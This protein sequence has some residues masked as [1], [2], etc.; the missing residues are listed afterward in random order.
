[1]DT[2]LEVSDPLYPPPH[3]ASRLSRP[4]QMRR[5]P[6]RDKAPSLSRPS[7]DRDPDD[8]AP[9][10]RPTQADDATIDEIV[11]WLGERGFTATTVGERR[12]QNERLFVIR[13]AR[14]CDELA[15]DA[16]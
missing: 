6:T 12:A 10:S 8:R 5:A 9:F 1:M 7:P 2:I 3:P 11:A 15:L 13:F 16:G 14:G 4:T